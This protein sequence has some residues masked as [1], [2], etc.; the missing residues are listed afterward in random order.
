MEYNPFNFEGRNKEL[1]NKLFEDFI[2]KPRL[3]GVDWS[4]GHGMIRGETISRNGNVIEV[5]FKTVALV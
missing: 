2:I 1:I 4:A 5:R 3:L